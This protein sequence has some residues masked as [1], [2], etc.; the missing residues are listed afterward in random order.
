MALRVMPMEQSAKNSAPGI[1]SNENG[2][3]SESMPDTRTRE[4][5]KQ[6][7]RRKTDGRHNDHRNEKQHRGVHRLTGDS[8]TETHVCPDAK[9]PADCNCG[10]Y[11]PEEYS[12]ELQEHGTVQVISDRIS[13]AG[14]AS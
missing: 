14:W 1:E 7:E 13:E 8:C 11:K 6:M 9:Y 12:G 3:T 5:P 2:N 10:S 4:H